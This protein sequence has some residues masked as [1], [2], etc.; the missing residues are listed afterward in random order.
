MAVAAFLAVFAFMNILFLMA[1][2]TFLRCF[3]VF[4]FGFVAC[5]TTGFGMY[6]LELEIGPGMIESGRVHQDDFCIPAFMFGM[7]VLAV[8]L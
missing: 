6:A 5:V 7:T 1:A 2:V 4:L 8:G 3:M